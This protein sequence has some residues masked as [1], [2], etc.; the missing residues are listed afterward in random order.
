LP[1]GKWKSLGVRLRWPRRLQ[2]ALLLRQ[3]RH[4]P[5]PLSITFGHQKK[6]SDN[7]SLMQLS[8]PVRKSLPWKAASMVAWFPTV[9]SASDVLL[10]WEKKVTV[11]LFENSG[12]PLPTLN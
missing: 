2:L 12:F 6:F 1:T 5:S 9:F 11:F 3:R 10:R 4:L 8:D 7:Y